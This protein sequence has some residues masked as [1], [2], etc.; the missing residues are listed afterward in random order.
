MSRLARRRPELVEYAIFRPA[1][2][3]NTK[4]DHDGGR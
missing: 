1:E 3:V 4:G 2:P